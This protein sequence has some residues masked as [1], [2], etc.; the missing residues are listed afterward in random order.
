MA[1]DGSSTSK[2]PTYTVEELGKQL[3]KA[4]KERDEALQEN[5]KL[6]KKVEQLDESEELEQTQAQLE[7]ANRQIMLLKEVSNNR[8][9]RAKIATPEK[10][11]GDKT[12]L[13]G[14]LTQMRTYHR[15]YQS[16]LGSEPDKVV[17][18]AG[19][20]AGDALT[21]F[22]PSLRDFMEN[23]DQPSNMRPE[24]IESFGDYDRFEQTLLATF[25]EADEERTKENELRR[26]T[27]KG[28]ASQYAAKFKQIAAYLK[29]DPSYLMGAF[30]DGLKEHVKDDLYKEDKPNTLN[31]YIE[32]AVKIDNRI[33]QRSLQKRGQKTSPPSHGAQR[34]NF[35]RSYKPNTGYRRQNGNTSWGTHS[36]PMEID[37]NQVGKPLKDKSTIKCY[38][39]NKM[40][41]FAREC[42]EKRDWKAVPSGRRNVSFAGAAQISMVSASAID[43][44]EVFDDHEDYEVD[45]DDTSQ[46][47]ELDEH[48]FDEHWYTKAWEHVSI[49]ISEGNGQYNKARLYFEYYQGNKHTLHQDL[50]PGNGYG[51]KMRL[52][53]TIQTHHRDGGLDEFA[54]Y[55]E[56]A[57]LLEVYRFYEHRKD[58]LE[59][60]S[61]DDNRMP[62]Y[63]NSEG[64][65][66]PDEQS[67]GDTGLEPGE[68]SREFDPRLAFLRR[69][70]QLQRGQR[71]L[72]GEVRQTFELVKD[73]HDHMG[74][75]NEPRT[76]WE[77]VPETSSPTPDEMNGRVVDGIWGPTPE[78]LERIV[79]GA[80]DGRTARA[81]LS[82]NYTR[83][84]EVL[85][86][87]GRQG[88]PSP[89]R[90]IRDTSTSTAEYY[91]K[92]NENNPDPQE[93]S[94]NAPRCEFIRR[95]NS[96]IRE[97]DHREALRR[98]QA[99]KAEIAREAEET[100]EEE[101]P[102]LTVEEWTE[103]YLQPK[104]EDLQRKTRRQM[105]AALK[106]ID[107]A[108]WYNNITP[109][110]KKQAKDDLRQC[111]KE[112]Q[113]DIAQ[114][115]RQGVRKYK[116]AFQQ[117]SKNE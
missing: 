18:T 69:L 31:E 46:T 44:N 45:E 80:A 32:M 77:P 47:P 60:S 6:E 83:P 49:L 10:F 103:Q 43:P 98:I 86:G 55:F 85:R 84:S 12:K 115:E 82:M 104:I 89:Y 2:G 34:Q 97:E 24:T 95:T 38:N 105:D 94:W 51:E 67:S 71:I 50:L 112:V 22:E 70:R 99:R 9:T 16:D 11:N 72:K 54:R 101:E 1:N 91:G 74:L 88:H 52:W 4:K 92:M 14:F 30:Y 76:I 13:R 78:F 100:E 110:E 114:L 27:Q 21:W 73:I 53:Y 116:E 23:H 8:A 113:D 26:L 87:T 79:R 42:K 62:G 111:E 117:Y 58:A 66:Q 35:Q 7:E 17:C 33:Y 63:Y 37:A 61:T 102:S 108:S 5:K 65:D 106:I 40:G 15:F 41:H 25:G 75:N 28:S 90:N 48:G 59:N 64:D 29:W 3:A 57:T 20:L 56:G 19:F 36:G 81:N 93:W 109:E 39:C 107:L 68:V 96:P